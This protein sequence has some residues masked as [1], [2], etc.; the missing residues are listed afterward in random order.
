[1]TQRGPDMKDLT[2]LIEQSRKQAAREGRAYKHGKTVARTPQGKPRLSFSQLARINLCAKRRSQGLP[3][4]GVDAPAQSAQPIHSQG[5]EG[6]AVPP[7]LLW[8]YG[9][10]TV[11]KR[12]HDLLPRTLASLS[13]G[14]FERPR[15]FVDGCQDSSL[16]TSLQLP[17][18]LRPLIRAAG[19]WHL[20]LLELYL[21]SPLADRYAI[22]QDDIVCSRNLRAY[23]E[24]WYPDKGYLSLYTCDSN[25]KH[26]RTVYGLKQSQAP[27]IGWHPSHQLGRGALGLVFSNEAL[28][29]LIRSEHLNKKPKHPTR[30]WKSLDGGIVEALS[31]EQGWKEFVHY[32]SLLQHTGIQSCVDKDKFATAHNPNHTVYTWTEDSLSESFQGEGFDCLSFLQG[33]D[34]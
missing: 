23:L 8:S 16:Y 4:G 6:N 34:G 25:H 11:P 9:V 33:D 30:G 28:L 10:T 18:T 7:A 12:R 31:R 14:G 3:C 15:L 17:F 13:Q 5:E 1:M 24:T 2:R 29:T 19:N 21:S 27:P 26:I 22:F 20:T 32:P